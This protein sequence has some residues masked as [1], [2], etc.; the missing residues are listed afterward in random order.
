MDTIRFRDQLDRDVL[1]KR[2]PKRIISIVPSITELL[3]FLGFEDEVIAITKFCVHPQEWF[4]TK[5]RIGGTKSLKIQ[6][7]IDLKPDLVIGNKEENT[8]E[9]ISLLEKKVPVWMSDINSFDDALDFIKRLGSIL[10][11]EALCNDLVRTLNSAF[12]RLK[13]LGKKRTAIYFIWNNP[14]YIAGSG[15]FISGMLEQIGFINA[16]K[17]SRYPATD[18][19]PILNP[20]FVFLSSEPYPF[21]EK[22]RRYYQQCYPNAKILLVDGEMFSWYGSR[23]LKAIDYFEEKFRN[24]E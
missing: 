5:E 6:N 23:M 2:K 14:A 3:Y 15:T 9:D 13:D 11:K 17:D 4:E 7:I 20:E 1:I 18:K 10:N 8:K 24:I 12:E 21:E 22:H 16:C 19:L